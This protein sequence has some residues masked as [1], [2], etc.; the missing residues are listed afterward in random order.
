MK[1]FSIFMSLI[2][3]ITMAIADDTTNVVVTAKNCD[4]TTPCYIIKTSAN[5]LSQAV[6]QDISSK[7][8]MSMI[9]NSIVP[10]ID[11]TLMT[12]LAM[13]ANWK[14]ATTD[15]QTQVT[16]L[17]KQLLVNSYA[18][19]LSKFKGADVAIIKSAIDSDNPNKGIVNST[20]TMPSSDNKAQPINVEYNLTNKNAAN[21][22]KIYDV[23][24]ENASL[25]T[26]YRNQFNDI[27]QKDGVDGLI[28]QLQTKVDGM[29]KN[30]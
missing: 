29:K 14:Q 11:F 15:Q 20:I 23:K 9:Q 4:A 17:F 13:G 26:T 25:S 12:K 19:A 22:W 1:K 6:N 2:F 8:A 27:I 30:N 5:T 16:A 18:I 10:Q 7:Q 24:I 3:S 21:T 28:A